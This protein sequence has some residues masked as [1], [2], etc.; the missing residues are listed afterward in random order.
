MPTTRARSAKKPFPVGVQW[1][2][3]PALAPGDQPFA[4][5]LPLGGRTSAH[6]S[7]RR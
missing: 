7:A 3:R 4:S 1:G 2:L 6:S 5:A